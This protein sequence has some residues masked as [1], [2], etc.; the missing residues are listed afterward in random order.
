MTTAERNRLIKRV[1]S[2]AFPGIKVTVRGG[3]GTANGWVDI[4]I[5]WTPRDTDQRRELEALVWQL[6]DAAKLSGHI[7]TYGYDDPGSDYGYG[8]ECHISFNA[9]RYRQTMRHN[10]GTMSGCDWDGN[11]SEVR[12]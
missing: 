7:G 4:D 12:V 5:D 9:A 11:W 10:D 8:R 2:K 1:V 3:R 6:M